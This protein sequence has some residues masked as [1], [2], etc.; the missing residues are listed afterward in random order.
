MYLI[1]LSVREI[2]V[3]SSFQLLFQISDNLLIMSLDKFVEEVN[4]SN[5][6]ERSKFRLLFNVMKTHFLLRYLR[7][8]QKLFLMLLL[9]LAGL[10]G[11]ARVFLDFY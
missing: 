9:L 8:C 6:F 1:A 7:M 5:A 11:V 2:F 4:I 3:N 10:P